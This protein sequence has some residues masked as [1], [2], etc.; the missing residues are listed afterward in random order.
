MLTTCLAHSCTQ[1]DSRSHMDKS[2]LV[3][4][5]APA[6]VRILS[7]KAVPASLV[8]AAFLHLHFG[9]LQTEQETRSVDEQCACQ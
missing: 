2:L 1:F 5:R 7:T 9:Y 3:L 8:N 6:A 4:Q